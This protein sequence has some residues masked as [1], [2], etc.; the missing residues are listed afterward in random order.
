MRQQFGLT[1]YTTVDD[2]DTRSVS[3]KTTGL[4][5]VRVSV[6]LSAKADGT[7]LKPMIVF[8][9]AKRELKALNEEFRS[10]CVIV[11]SINGWM[12][13][14]L[15]LVWVERV[16]GK[17]S[18]GRCLL[19][20]DSFECHMM[21]SV[22]EAVTTSKS[23]LVIVPGGCTK[24]IQAP[25][26]CWNKPFKAFIGTKCDEWMSEGV[27]QYAEAAAANGKFISGA[28]VF[29]AVPSVSQPINFISNFS[30]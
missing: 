27:H 14:E 7:K 12:N 1:W 25:D 19:S 2:I 3:L 5:K 20:W 24:Y 8:G 6:C 28:K 29:A 10:R 15:T 26:V 22:K 21:D 30:Y 23:D 18:F 11:S 17:F 9:G 16:F 4:E 13:E